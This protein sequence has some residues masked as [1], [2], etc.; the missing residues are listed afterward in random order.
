MAV[1]M[2]EPSVIRSTEVIQNEDNITVLVYEKARDNAGLKQLALAEWKDY[3]GY[4]QHKVNN[5]ATLCGFSSS[6]YDKN[7]DI[8]PPSSTLISQ[9]AAIATLTGVSTS[10]PSSYTSLSDKIDTNTSSINTIN[11]NINAINTFIGNETVP[12]NNSLKK[13]LDKVYDDVENEST[14][15]KTSVNSLTTTI[16]AMSGQ[17]TTLNSNVTSLQTTVNDSNSGVAA[18]NVKVNRLTTEVEAETTGL[19]SRVAVLEGKSTS[20]ESQLSTLW[21]DVESSGALKDKVSSL[22]TTTSS[23]QYIVNTQGTRLNDAE[24]GINNLQDFVGYPSASA[25]SDSLYTHVTQN[26]S[27]IAQ[28]TSSIESINNSITDINM[29]LGDDTGG[30]VKD[31]AD[32]TERNNTES[33]S[34]SSSNLNGIYTLVFK[35]SDNDILSIICTFND[36][37]ATGTD[38]KYILMGSTK[39]NPDTNDYFTENEGVISS[40]SGVTV[41]FSKIG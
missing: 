27:A 7:Y 6:Q 22:E 14:G 13:R 34:W 17:V 32:L 16:V 29:I 18:L 35:N 36:G 11:S 1:P 15:L 37:V 9:I 33:G 21:D 20:V 19:L 38:E 41:G 30:L 2:Q 26:T 28:N 23:L 25:Q 8:D 12:G 39:T 10:I 4:N 3:L 24:T 31:V 40:A 5:V